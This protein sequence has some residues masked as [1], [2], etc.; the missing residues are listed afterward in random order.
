MKVTIEFG[1]YRD[2]EFHADT[3]DEVVSIINLALKEGY[4]AIV[5]NEKPE[6]E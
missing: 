6:D 1:T 5:E 4:K 3:M 2:V